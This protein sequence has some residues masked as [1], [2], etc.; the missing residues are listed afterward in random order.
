MSKKMLGIDVFSASKERISWTFDNFKKVCVSFSGGKD[1][2]AMLHMVMEEAIKRNVKVA[3]MF[4]DW[5][6]QYET[7]INHV[8]KMFEKYK[9]NIIPFWVAI[10][11]LSDNS[12]SQFEPEWI[13]WD[14]EKKELWTREKEKMSISNK[15]YFPFYYEKIT[16]EEFVP[17]FGAWYGNGDL[18]AIL[19]GIRTQE[20]LNRYRTL[21]NTK[22]KLHG[23]E[24][25]TTGITETVFNVYPIYDWTATDDWIYFSK[26][27]KCYNEIYD[28]MYQAGLTI[29]QMRIDE[30]FGATARKGLWMYQIIEPQTWSKMILRL[31]GVNTANLYSKE[32]G[33]ILGNGKI[34]LPKNH[35]WK[36]F[37][38]HLL[39]TMPEST[40]NHYI[41]KI[42]V[43]IKWFETRGYPDGIPDQSD[44]KLE[45]LNK[46][47]SWR[48][49]CRTLLRNDYWCKGI[50]FSPTKTS[51]YKNY[52]S[53]MS[54]RKE[55]WNIKIF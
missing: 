54:K 50:G 43:Y 46:V 37:S 18:T 13:A 52:L 21:A 27:K 32:M 53:M 38:Y 36:S 55:K 47:P 33:N 17:L 40:A 1:S 30:P 8:R 41:N 16:F 31:S 9:E 49:I 7:T 22:K 28:R 48:R 42:T 5:E 26:F 39:K 11:I 15:S 44:Y 3:V 4:L 23:G 35:T 45:Q 24:M 25:F 20:S 34:S 2:T 14:E 19:V 6:C 29:H 12:C 10:P 51:A